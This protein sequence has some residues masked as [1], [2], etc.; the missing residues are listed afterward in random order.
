[1]HRVLGA[2]GYAA[3]MSIAPGYVSVLATGL[4]RRVI[5]DIPAFIRANTRVAAPPHT[6]E[7]RLHLAD[8][9]VALWELTETA[10]GEIGLPPPFWAFAWAGGQALARYVLDHPEIVCGKSV[11]DIGAGAGLVAIAAALAG[12]EKAV[13]NDVDAF[14]AE[15]ARLNAALNDVVI[16]P[17]TEDMIGKPAAADIILVGDLCYQQD[18]AARLIAWLEA[19]KAHGKTILIGD[20][21]RTYLP[22]EGLTRIAEYDVPTIRALEDSDMKRTG[23]WRL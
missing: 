18:I 4:I 1:M 16:E 17:R 15:A 20:P 12:A 11:L 9:A 21:G 23:V 5:A 14:A 2:K 3:R 7:I 10:L 22:K 6:P 19:E 13:A 8:D